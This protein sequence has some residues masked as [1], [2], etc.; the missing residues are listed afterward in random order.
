MLL[1]A[2]RLVQAQAENDP[3][4]LLSKTVMKP[5]MGWMAHLSLVGHLQDEGYD[6]IPKKAREKFRYARLG[7]VEHGRNC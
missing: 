4:G 1:G 6:E 7:G 3:D 2:K 5:L